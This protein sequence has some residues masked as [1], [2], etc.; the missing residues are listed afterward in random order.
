LL[1]R[2]PARWLPEDDGLQ[3]FLAL[4]EPRKEQFLRAMERAEA[5]MSRASGP[6][7][8]ARMRESWDSGRFWFNLAS[9]SS[10]HLD[11]IYWKVLSKRRVGGP[12]V[13]WEMVDTGHRFVKLKMEQYEQ[14]KEQKESDERFTTITVA[15]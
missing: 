9:R 4:F 10:F 14:W 12:V 8:S 3:K 2:H 7:L 13:D 1:L 5:R 11:E 6:R 15:V